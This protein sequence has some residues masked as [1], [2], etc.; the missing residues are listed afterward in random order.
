[1]PPISTVGTP[2]NKYIWMNKSII[3]SSIIPTVLLESK[4]PNVST[5]KKKKIPKFQIADSLNGWSFIYNSFVAQP[6][7]SFYL[8]NLS[9]MPGNYWK[10]LTSL[11]FSWYRPRVKKYTNIAFPGGS[12]PHLRYCQM[13]DIMIPRHRKS[14]IFNFSS[15]QD[16]T[17]VIILRNCASTPAA[18]PI[19]T[20]KI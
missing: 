7:L 5:L 13:D 19:S 12:N 18:Y 16:Q 9:K 8:T 4:K 15:T 1:M 10:P 6:T 2:S 3:W 11:E 20:Y 14:I 17:V